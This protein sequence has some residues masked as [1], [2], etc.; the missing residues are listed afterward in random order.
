MIYITRQM[1]I[2]RIGKDVWEYWNLLVKFLS[3]GLEGMMHN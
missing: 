3:L 2:I 1:L